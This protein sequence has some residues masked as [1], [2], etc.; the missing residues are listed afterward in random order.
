MRK[1]LRLF[2]MLI[3]VLLFA[4]QTQAQT[5]T[6]LGTEVINGSYQQYALTDLCSFSQVRL[7]ATTS[8]GGGSGL[9]GARKWEFYNGTYVNNWRPYTAN[10]TLAGFNQQILPVGGTASGLYNS[11]TGGQP[12]LLPNVTANNYYTFNIEDAAGAINHN[13]SVLETSYNPQSI[14]SVIQSFVLATP[15]CRQMLITANFSGALSVGEYA[16][17]RY[18]TDNFATS[19]I[20]SINTAGSTGTTT[21]PAFAPGTVVKYYVFTSNQ[22]APTPANADMLTLSISN[23]AC[24]NFTYNS[25]TITSVSQSPALATPDCRQ[26]LVTA[27]FSGALSSGEY[28][29]V[30]YTTDNFATS[31]ITRITTAGLATGTA[32]IPAFASGTVVK[33]YVFTS[34]QTTPT[35][36]TVNT[37]TQ[38]ISNAGCANFTYTVPPTPT[39][40]ITN[41]VPICAGSSIALN[42]AT[43]TPGGAAT[44][45]SYLWFSGAAAPTAASTPLR[46]GTTLPVSAAG[47]YWLR[48]TNTNGC[49]AQA[50][51]VVTAA[52]ATAVPVVVTPVNYCEG[53]IAAPLSATGTGLKWYSTTTTNTYNQQATPQAPVPFA[54]INNNAVLT[55]LPSAPTPP[56]TIP[57]AGLQGVHNTSY[58]VSQ[59][60]AVT[61]CESALVKIGVEVYAKPLINTTVGCGYATI[62]VSG[63]ATPT[64][65]GPAPTIQWLAGS[66]TGTPVTTNVT[67]VGTT[68]T[69]KCNPGTYVVKVTCNNT[70]PAPCFGTTSTIVV[71]P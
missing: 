41:N 36:A 50:S 3:A 64:P 49:T 5:P 37:I 9:G 18:T 60:D 17:V 34:N 65:P 27:N 55:L 1:T 67:T 31:T 21:I 32:T 58:Y 39:P 43:S 69:I 30:C 22:I 26:T 44:I 24:A 70:L 51:V 4:L 45:T 61:G 35:L 25:T 33:Y 47:T 46:S 20:V 19:T 38:S 52:A 8:G 42:G 13:M 53:D 6:N 7:Q 71:I 63:C 10:L 12:G 28:A 68:S 2:G 23:A 62:S 11:N 14:T 56:T 29:F 54:T 40:I 15:S 57:V 59:T 48:T 66:A 16:F